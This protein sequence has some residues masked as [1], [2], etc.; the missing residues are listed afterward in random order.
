MLNV[1]LVHC[2]KH[3]PSVFQDAALFKADAVWEVSVAFS[4]KSKELPSHT[5][6]H[7]GAHTLTFLVPKVKRYDRAK[8]NSFLA[9]NMENT[10]HLR[11]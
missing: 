5:H 7:T 4:K 3:F 9:A 1:R 6:T 8:T 2:F 11:M 10:L